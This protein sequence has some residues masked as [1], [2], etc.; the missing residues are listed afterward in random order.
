LDFREVRIMKVIALVVLLACLCMPAFCQAPAAPTMAPPDVPTFGS[1]ELVTEINVSDQDL[2]QYLQLG[3]MAFGSTA[4][5]A[6]GEMGEI[7][8][9]IDLETLASA[10]S[11]LKYVRVLQFKMAKPDGAKKILDFYSSGVG[12]GWN[13]IMWDVSQ[14]GQGYA[15]LAKPGMSEA[16]AVA[17]MPEGARKLIPANAET[18]KPAAQQAQLIIVGRT[19]GMVDV[20]KLG[21][22][23]GTAMVKFS[24]MRERKAG[25]QAVKKPELAKP[26]AKTA[27]TAQKKTTKK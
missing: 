10:I 15:I 18:T 24:Q 25:A 21:A 4:K 22:W 8:Q 23:A 13:R 20:Q 7:V 19:V 1:A 11:D 14:P 27:P 6:Q 26:A 2:L 17:V 16:L 3:M 9:A 12:E 5:S